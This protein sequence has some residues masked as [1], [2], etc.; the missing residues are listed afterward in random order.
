MKIK[1]L[2]LSIVFSTV[3][4][5][6][7]SSELYSNKETILIGDSLTYTYQ[8]CTNDMKMYYKVGTG[9]HYWN[10]K[11]KEIDLN[12][13]S[14]VI[15]S[16]GTNDMIP[17]SYKGKYSSE[18]NKFTNYLNEKDIEVVWLLPVSLRDP[19]KN[20]LIR[21]TREAILSSTNIS[22]FIHVEDI[23]SDP[24]KMKDET[25]RKI[26]TADGIHITKY[27]ACKVILDLRQGK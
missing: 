20:N 23:L 13:V 11:I 18:V 5:N 21:N 15:V 14:T 4:F 2:L 25:N 10:K 7:F 24:F 3:S 8:Q 19:K 27:G 22:R 1:N 26:R 16:I 17:S 12:N 6:S 9:I